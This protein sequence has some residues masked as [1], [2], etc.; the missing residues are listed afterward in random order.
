[1]YDEDLDFCRRLQRRGETALY[2]PSVELVHVGGA[3]STSDHKRALSRRARSVYYRRNHGM[4]AEAAFR[5][6]H[7]AVDAAKG[8]HAW[9]TR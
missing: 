8:G 2:V 7:G 3:S 5:L 1:M 4:L 9:L 6:L